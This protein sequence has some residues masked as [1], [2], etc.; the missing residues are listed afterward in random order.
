MDWKG[1]MGAADIAK[2]TRVELAGTEQVEGRDTY[3]LKLTMKDGNTTHIWIDAETFLE[4]KMEGQSRRLDGVEHPVEI[5]YRDYRRVDGLQIPYLLETMVLPVTRTAAG[6]K[7]PPVPVE[8]IVIEKITV[9]PKLDD[10]LF[11]KPV[12]TAAAP[13]GGSPAPLNN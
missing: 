12:V 5:Y 10:S 8:K 7:D 2:G 1:K 4:A 6:P 13:N 9:N 11:L 3:K